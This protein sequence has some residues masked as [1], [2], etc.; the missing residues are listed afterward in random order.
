MIT[1]MIKY[2]GNIFLFFNFSTTDSSLHKFPTKKNGNKTIVLESESDQPIELM[3]P[4]PRA[5]TMLIAK[6][7]FTLYN[8]WKNIFQNARLSKYH[9]VQYGS[10]AK[11]APVNLWA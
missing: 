8:I 1:E 10:N 3:V 9:R 2:N 4:T 6:I 7:N 11:V 5:N